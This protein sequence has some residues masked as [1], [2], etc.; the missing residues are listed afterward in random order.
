MPHK[1]QAANSSSRDAGAIAPHRQD[2]L[3]VQLLADVVSVVRVAA[4]LDRQSREEEQALE[5]R[6]NRQLELAQ[7]LEHRSSLKEETLLHL[8]ATARPHRPSLCCARAKDSAIGFTAIV[9]ESQVSR[10]RC[11]TSMG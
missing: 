8:L 5:V 1:A 9:S 7:A 10:V 2:R 11:N 6:C 3:E 4:L